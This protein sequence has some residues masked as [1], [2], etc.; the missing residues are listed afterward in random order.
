MCI[1]LVEVFL[2]RFY[3]YYVPV[4]MNSAQLT[5]QGLVL[6]EHNDQHYH[7]WFDSERARDVTLLRRFMKGQKQDE[8]RRKWLREHADVKSLTHRQL[9]KYY[10][11][12]K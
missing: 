12:V 7:N 10:R 1:F 9:R 11:Y 2:K 5:Q 6:I 8:A 4:K 3:N